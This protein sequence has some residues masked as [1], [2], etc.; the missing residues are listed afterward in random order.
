M[1]HFI[2][3]YSAN[4]EEQLD[5]PQLLKVLNDTAVSTGVFLWG[6]S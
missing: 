2:V 1:P 6:H 5:I 4:I 3:E